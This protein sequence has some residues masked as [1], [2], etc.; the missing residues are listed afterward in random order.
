MRDATQQAA[1]ATGDKGRGDLDTA[2]ASEDERA[3]SLD[4]LL[5]IPVAASRAASD[6][7]FAGPVST[8]D[9]AVLGLPPENR[10]EAGATS[11]TFIFPKASGFDP[12][13]LGPTEIPVDLSGLDPSTTWACVRRVNGSLVMLLVVETQVG[14]V[15][16]ASRSE[17]LLSQSAGAA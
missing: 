15:V 2:S 14:W 17:E 11:S 4:E 9:C 1:N 12:R 5:L 13:S 8:R 3:L 10:V 6:R 7:R 16:T